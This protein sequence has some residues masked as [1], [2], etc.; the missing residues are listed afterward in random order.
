MELACR[1]WNAQNVEKGKI[2]LLHGMG[3]TGAIWRPIA[4]ALES[5]FS[6][7]A[8]DQRGHGSSRVKTVSGGRDTASYTPL[9]YGKDLVETL[10]R[11][12]FHPAWVVGHSMGVRS[13]CA[14]A[15]LKSQW[16]RGLVLVD[17]GFTG[18]AGGGLGEDLARFLRK[19]PMRFESRAQA[20][21]FLS[22]ECP[23]PSMAQYLLAVSVPADSSAAGVGTEGAITF[24]FDRSALIQTIEASRDTSV[25]EW[26]RAM[27]LRG[28]PIL[29]L[30]GVESRVWSRDDFQA[31]K[32]LLRDLHSIRFEEVAGAGHGLPFEKRLEF[33]NRL[34][35]FVLEG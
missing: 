27:G 28:M 15:H 18:V 35:H 1:L 12:Q 11:R 2:L 7:L 31:E 32:G 13:A 10:D 22:R 14:L 24:P 9:D 23:E 8:P 6:V 16:V 30:R 21:E 34:K 29:V 25:R 4:A 5:D 26:V 19:L 20:R 17:L 33:V 3:G